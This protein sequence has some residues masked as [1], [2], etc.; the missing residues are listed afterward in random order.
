MADF[1]NTITRPP[2]TSI[3][4]VTTYCTIRIKLAR[5]TCESRQKADSVSLSSPIASRLS[6]WVDV[7]ASP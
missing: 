1:L 6:P 3:P 4:L 2:E 7:D 5:A